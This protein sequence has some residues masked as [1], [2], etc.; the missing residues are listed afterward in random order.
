VPWVVAEGKCALSF[1]LVNAAPRVSLVGIIFA[2]HA[3][4]A[5]AAPTFIFLPHAET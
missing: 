4:V 3:S 1:T 2:D 5:A